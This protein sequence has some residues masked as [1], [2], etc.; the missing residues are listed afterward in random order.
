MRGLRSR[1]SWCYLSPKGQ[2]VLWNGGNN[3][4]KEMTEEV[5]LT[6]KMKSTS[7]VHIRCSKCTA[8]SDSDNRIFSTALTGEFDRCERM[9]NLR[10]ICSKGFSYESCNCSESDV[11]LAELVKAVDSRSAG[12]KHRVGSSPT[13]HTCPRSQPHHTLG[14]VG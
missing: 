6:F 5:W 4:G 3:T 8:I 7:K 9:S 10:S 12:A 1:R 11:Y 2:Y 13:V 14:R